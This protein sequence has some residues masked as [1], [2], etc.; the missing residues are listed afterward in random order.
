M[1]DELAA[2]P[3]KKPGRPRV[4][5]Q[6]G[7]ELMNPSESSGFVRRAKVALELPLIDISDAEQVKERV[8][9]YMEHCAEEGTIPTKS[10]AAAWLGI[11]RSTLNSWKRGEYRQN[12]HYEFARRLD[13]VLESML[14][15]L[16]VSNKIFPA[17]GMFL[18]KNYND[19]RDQID[20]APATAQPL[21][22]M[23]DP[24]ALRKKI[25]ANIIDE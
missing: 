23:P 20:I 24:E 22:D 6:V 19:F 17:S 18:L 13:Q 14:V 4:K 7:E 15:E 12:T 5:P 8:Y 21:G 11:D 10:G 3:K 2:P 16:L 1:P 9:A 25:E